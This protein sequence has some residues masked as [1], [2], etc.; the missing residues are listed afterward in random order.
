MAGK[1]HNPQME[2]L[3]KP[4][5]YRVEYFMVALVVKMIQ[6]MPRQYG[7][8][9]MRALADAFH[10]LAP[11]HHAVMIYNLT[12]AFGDE[13]TV[14][15]IQKIARDAP[16]YFAVAFVD[17]LRI[18]NIIREGFD[19]YVKAENMDILDEA[20]RAGKG[21]ILLTG[22][23]GNWELMGAYVAQKNYPIKVVGSP[24]KNPLLDKLL[25]DM[26]NNAGYRNISRGR[27]AKG[28][29]RALKEGALLGI[30][31]DQDIK[32][33]NGVFVDFFGRKAHTP[34]GPVVLAAKFGIPIIPMF[35]HLEKDLTYNIQC[36][37][38]IE[39]T[40]TG[41]TERDIVTNT[42]KCSD[43]YEKII[44]QHPEQWVWIHRRWKQ[45]PNDI[46]SEK[47]GIL[48]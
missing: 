40:D 48:E 38:P 14:R 25:V 7:I 35:M 32:K 44:R 20:M 19:R 15:E 41:D 22:H 17:T 16:R 5:K 2:R 43:V 31:M 45:K 12:L 9:V 30:L 36:F 23:F 10:I 34:I 39:L 42:Q 24:L 8:G 18:P 29:L 26:R 46:Q 3:R 4:I 28:I 27:N 47:N 6:A 13:K 37:D 33:L 1:K 21:A 11:E